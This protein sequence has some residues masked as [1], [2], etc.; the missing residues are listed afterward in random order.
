MREETALTSEIELTDSGVGSA[1]EA[2]LRENGNGNGNGKGGG[3]DCPG[4]S[5]EQH[6][7]N[8]K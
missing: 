7:N 3:N 1:V 2:T 4:Q 5:C 8:N 6:G